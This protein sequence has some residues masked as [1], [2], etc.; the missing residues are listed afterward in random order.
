MHF[1]N[2][3]HD[4]SFP[5]KVIRARLFNHSL[6]QNTRGSGHLLYFSHHDRRE[7]LPI[8]PVLRPDRRSAAI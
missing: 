8:C 1:Q 6:P 4:I 2:A 3:G 5:A 7:A